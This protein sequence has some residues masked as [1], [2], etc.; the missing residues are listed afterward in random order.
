MVRIQPG[1][2]HNHLAIFNPSALTN[3]R[4]S[5]GIKGDPYEGCTTPSVQDQ[6]SDGK[7]FFEVSDF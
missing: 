3:D 6:L 1:L 4:Y 7:L 5:D 2:F